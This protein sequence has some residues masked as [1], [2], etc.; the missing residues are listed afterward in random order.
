MSVEARQEN[1]EEQSERKINI[2]STSQ[3]QRVIPLNNSR[4]S[5][6]IG[7]GFAI[8]ALRILRGLARGKRVEKLK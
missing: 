6:Y 4:T 5:K 2:D 8:L 3:S 7:K 1:R